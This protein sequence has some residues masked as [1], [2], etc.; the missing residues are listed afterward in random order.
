MTWP[1]EGWI[2]GG[3]GLIL[4]VFL[5][6]THFQWMALFSLFFTIFWMGF[7][8][9]PHRSIPQ[10]KDLW[11]A[12]ADGKIVEVN[13]G[14]EGN[15]PRIGIFMNVWHVHV[16][17]IPYRGR[18]VSILRQKGKYLPAFN[19][20]AQHVNA[21]VETIVDSDCGRYRIRQI[22]GILARR[23]RIW[24]KPD[25][26]VQTGQPF[27]IILLGSRVDVLFPEHVDI[28]VK[29]GEKV[30]AGETVIA[31]SIQES[32]GYR[33]HEPFQAEEEESSSPP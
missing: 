7:T 20:S 1:R 22:A 32:R 25:A 30:R 13:K 27:G 19:P 29:K 3:A 21:Q 17:R 16:N 23:I 15:P 14:D 28:V 2:G 33:N 9:H 8:R 12:P 10:E 5:Y 6:F 18:I 11:V 24:T 31:R 26:F 4:T